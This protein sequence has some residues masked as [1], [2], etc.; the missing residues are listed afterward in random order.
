MLRLL[1]THAHAEKLRFLLAGGSTTAVSYAVYLGLL[2]L[3]VHAMTSYV[4]SYFV[5][6]I[7]SYLVN[8]MWVFQSRPGWRS[9]FRYPLVYILQAVASFLLFPL[10]LK[11]GVA[12]WLA[13]LLVT[14]M[15]LPVTF[16]LSRAFAKR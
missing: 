12:R 15:L 1:K 2:A 8:V 13:P 3:G 10:L 5:G 16:V 9:V 14:I 6:I 7:W 11:L 4:A